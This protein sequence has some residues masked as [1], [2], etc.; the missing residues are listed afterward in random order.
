MSTAF[1]LGSEKIKN[2]TVAIDQGVLSIVLKNPAS[3]DHI[4]KGKDAIVNGKRVEGTMKHYPDQ[5]ILTINGLDDNKN[6]TF[7]SAF[8]AQDIKITFDESAICALLDAI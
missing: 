3:E 6:F 8:Y 4:L 2:F 1:Y 5:Q 7:E